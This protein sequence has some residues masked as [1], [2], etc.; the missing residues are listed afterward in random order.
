MKKV[1]FLGMAV[2]LMSFWSLSYGQDRSDSLQNNND[3]SS[4][5]QD[6]KRAGKSTGQAIKKAAKE[7]GQETSE[8]AAKGFAEVTDN[9]YKGKQG[10]NGERIYIDKYDHT[11]FINQK[12]KKVYISKEKLKDKAE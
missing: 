12:G 4:I 7:V 11:Y 8:A 3:T 1:I 6:L 10:P 2:F 5:G 9:V